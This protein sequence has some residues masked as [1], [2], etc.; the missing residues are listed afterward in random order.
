M[1][2]PL[3]VRV[4]P[5]YPGLVISSDGR[6]QGP[7]GKWLKGRLDKD[8]YRYFSG[9]RRGGMR[10][11][12]TLFVHVVVCTA[13]HGS[14][15]SA[16]HQVAHGN[17]DNTD[18]RSGNLRWVTCKENHADKKRHGRTSVGVANPKAKLTE[19]Q[20]REIRRLRTQGIR[21]DELARRFGMDRHSITRITTGKAW[22][23]VQ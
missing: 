7:S 11:Q 18:N 14:R 6:I 2:A 22:G 21:N 8:G 12:S 5:E 4:V 15:P 16:R 3:R 1:K 9:P 10:R 23:H 17:G 13:F 20:V 19:D